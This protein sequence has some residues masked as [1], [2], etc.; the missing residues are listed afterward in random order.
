MYLI[1]KLSINKRNSSKNISYISGN[2]I[3]NYINPNGYYTNEVKKLKKDEWV[4][5]IKP[6][7]YIIEMHVGSNYKFDDNIES[8][9]QA[10]SFFKKYYPE[11]NFKAIYGYSW[12]FSPQIK[13]IID[14]PNSNISK[15]ID[16]GYIVPCTSGDSLAFEFIYWDSKM[17]VEKMPTNTSMLRNIK[18]YYENGGRINCGMYYFLV[19][20]IENICKNIYK[21]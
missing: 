8:F 14:N 15:M 5:V 12:L 6:G 11:H 2:F 4:E 9:K 18:K 19:D 20:D 17:T 16:T 7:D 1:S 13:N 3:G 10:I 21:K